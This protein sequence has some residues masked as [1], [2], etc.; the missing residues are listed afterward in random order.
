MGCHVAPHFWFVCWF[1]IFVELTGF[2]PVTSPDQNLDQGIK[3]CSN[4]KVLGMRQKVVPLR[5]SRLPDSSGIFT[6]AN[7]V[8]MEK[9]SRS[10]RRAK[11]VKKRMLTGQVR[12]ADVAEAV[13]LTWQPYR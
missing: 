13:Q 8:R 10:V 9:L 3:I 2:E 11:Q 7:G 4:F 12:T 5:P 6:F 1:K